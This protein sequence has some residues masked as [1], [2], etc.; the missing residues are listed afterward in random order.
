MIQAR[1]IS[2]AIDRDMKTIVEGLSFTVP[3]G[4]KTALIGEEGNGKSTLLK[5]L[6]DPA[7]V[8]GYATVSGS[9]T[10]SGTKGYL[11]QELP[12]QDRRRDPVRL[13][14]ARHP[15][16]DRRIGAALGA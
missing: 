14:G 5:W 6:Y 16:F 4:A 10:V 9:A 7:L 13:L 12:E 11:A 15:G 3:D 1:N 2:I 8:E